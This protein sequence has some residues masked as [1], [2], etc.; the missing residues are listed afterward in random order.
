MDQMMAALLHRFPLGGINLGVVHRHGP[1]EA[2]MVERC[3]STASMM[4][5]LGGVA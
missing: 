1:V 5:G 3:S 4:L 2:S